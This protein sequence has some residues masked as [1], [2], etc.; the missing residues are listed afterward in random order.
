MRN[1]MNERL[2]STLDRFK[3]TDRSACH[4]I[5]AVADSLGHQVNNLVI[6]R[7]SI[8]QLRQAHREEFAV[9]H[10][11]GFHVINSSIPDKPP[12]Y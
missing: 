9:R 4:V 12:Q 3:I 10:K 11:E 7:S 8:R 5:A 1:F 6:S 2:V